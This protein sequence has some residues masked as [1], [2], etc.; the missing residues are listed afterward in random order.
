MRIVIVC[1]ALCAGGCASNGAVRCDGRLEPINA[2][3]AVTSP[4]QALA[5]TWVSE[6]EPSPGR[7]VL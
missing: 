6:E 7:D 1:L 3:A 5:E 2:P 4:A